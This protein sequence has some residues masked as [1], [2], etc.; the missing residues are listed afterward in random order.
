MKHD[1]NDDVG[2]NIALWVGFINLKGFTVVNFRLIDCPVKAVGEGLI[3]CCVEGDQ[4]PNASCN[5]ERK[6]DGKHDEECLD[7]FIFS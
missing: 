5:L 4:I 2:N 7:E 6:R 3:S 1:G